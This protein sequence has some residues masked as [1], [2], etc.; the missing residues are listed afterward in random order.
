[1][2]EEFERGF[3]GIRSST[4][5]RCAGG[6]PHRHD[7][8]ADGQLVLAAWEVVRPAACVIFAWMAMSRW[9]TAR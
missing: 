1:M 6:E 3:A 5:S 7:H 9:D 4:S 8:E 2:V